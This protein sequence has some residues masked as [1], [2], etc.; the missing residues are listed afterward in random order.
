[1]VF[2]L[3][4]GKGFAVGIPSFR[5]VLV[6]KYLQRQFQQ[7]IILYSKKCLHECE[8]KGGFCMKVNKVISQIL[9]VTLLGIV[10][11]SIVNGIDYAHYFNEINQIELPEVVFE[12]NGRESGVIDRDG[13]VYRYKDFKSSDELFQLYRD[14]RMEKEL[15]FSGKVNK[16]VLKGK[17]KLFLELQA[18]DYQANQPKEIPDAFETNYSYWG[19]YYNSSNEIAFMRIYG[20]HFGEYEVNDNRGVRLANWIENKVT[21]S[22]LDKLF[23]L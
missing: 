3:F 19:Y 4:A 22:W 11:I 9:L 6:L 13:N 17:Y 5:V 21:E 20:Y 18:M 16:F 12:Y 7:Y 8:C 15:E 14:G 10:V 1:M 23:T 2:F